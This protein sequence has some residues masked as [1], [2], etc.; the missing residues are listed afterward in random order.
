MNA[1]RFKVNA[2]MYKVNAADLNVSAARPQTLLPA[3]EAVR[4]GGR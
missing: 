2:A 4:A 1:A 3:R